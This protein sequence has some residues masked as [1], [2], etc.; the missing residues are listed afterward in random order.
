M[1]QLHFVPTESALAYFEATRAYLEEHGKPVAFYSDKASIFRSVRDSVDFGRGVTQYGRAL[2]ELKNQGQAP[3][4]RK[5]LPG[6]KCSSQ[7]TSE[8]LELAVMERLQAI[9]VITQR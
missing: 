9:R 2:F 8:D 5:A 3:Y 4:P 6:A 7:F 1:M